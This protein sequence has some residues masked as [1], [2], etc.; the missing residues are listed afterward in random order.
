MVHRKILGEHIKKQYNIM[1]LVGNGFDIQV[2]NQYNRPT[3]TRYTDFYHFLKMNNVRTNNL[4]VQE[5]EAALDADAEDWSDIEACIERLVQQ[6]NRVKAIAKSVAEIRDYF[7]AFLNTVVDSR[8]L[9]DLSSDAEANE[10]SKQTFSTF[11]G[12]LETLEELQRVPFG[13]RKSVYDAYNFV[14]INFN[15]TSLL[16]NYLYMDSK[17]F[18]PLPHKTVDTNFV[19]NN[20]PK[21]LEGS[22]WNFNS[23]SY[24]EYQLIHPHGYQDIPRSLLFGVDLTG[25]PR[26]A[27]AH[28][29][30]PYW[31]RGESRYAHY[32]DDTDLFIVFGCS[33]GPTDTW[34]WQHIADSLLENAERALIIY[35]RNAEDVVA[36]SR[37]ETIAKFLAVTRIEDSDLAR[38]MEQISVVSYFDDTDRV[39]LSTTP[40]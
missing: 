38:L 30:K 2:L 17:Q 15:Y 28:L 16:D 21:G 33:I 26:A 10:W 35:W 32:F 13:A 40:Q 23:S 8:L 1:A 29:A 7:S 36:L 4:I 3:T 14:F 34:W 37:E 12:D 31:A 11:L 9:A 6:G 19:F 18:D 27:T 24:I 25:D 22:K 5:M 39:W 20:D